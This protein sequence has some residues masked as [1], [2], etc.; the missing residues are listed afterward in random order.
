MFLDDGVIIVRRSLIQG[1]ETI[2][3]VPFHDDNL[4]KINI[5]KFKK[6]LRH[7]K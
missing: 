2:A 6:I 1:T 4:G 3:S 7:R 5:F